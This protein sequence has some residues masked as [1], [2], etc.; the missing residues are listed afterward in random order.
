MKEMIDVTEYAKL[1]TRELKRG[2]L[3]NTNAD[4]FNA[5]SIG[6][7]AL[8]T[9]WNRPAF[10]VYVRDSRY[11]KYALDKSGEFT[12]SIPMGGRSS[13][14]DRVCGRLSGRDVDKAAEAGLSLEPP[15]VNS[16][17]GIREYPLT[18][19]CRVLY[20]QRQQFDSIPE[21]IVREDYPPIPGETDGS[22]RDL[23]TAYIGQIVSAYVIR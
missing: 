4:K 23:H 6:W 17:P 2:I 8:G 3:L 20:S 7:G 12:I 18:I 11:T 19:E 13:A 21:T 1:I 9:V 14:I 16:V 10:T 15:E 22:E 5:M